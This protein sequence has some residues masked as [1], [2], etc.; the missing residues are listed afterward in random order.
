MSI[1]GFRLSWC[2]PKSK[3]P[4]WFTQNLKHISA[5]T[6]ILELAWTSPALLWQR[7]Q[8]GSWWGSPAAENSQDQIWGV[9]QALPWLQGNHTLKDIITGIK[10]QHIKPGHDFTGSCIMAQLATRQ[11]IICC[12]GR[13]MLQWWS[14]SML[15]HGKSDSAKEQRS[16]PPLRARSWQMG[17]CI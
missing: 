8:G 6:D 14:R 13:S 3:V 10:P 1:T 17:C 2:C 11:G 15:L 5:Y 16:Q 7:R 9:L 4:P 12:P